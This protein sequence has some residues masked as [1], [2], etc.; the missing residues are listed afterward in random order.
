VDGVRVRDWVA[1][2]AEGQD[3]DDVSC[4]DRTLPAAQTPA[5]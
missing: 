5:E 2:L 4:S 1:A 3:V